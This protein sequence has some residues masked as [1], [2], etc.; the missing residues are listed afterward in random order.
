MLIILVLAEPESKR[1]VLAEVVDALLAVICVPENELC[2]IAD[3]LSVALVFGRPP[4]AVEKV[5]LLGKTEP[6]T[7]A[8]VL[9]TPLSLG[10]LVCM[11]VDPGNSEPG[12]VDPGYI[13]VSM[14]GVIEAKSDDRRM[15]DAEGGLIIGVLIL[16]R[17]DSSELLGVGSE[18]LKSLPA[19]VNPLRVLSAEVESLRALLAEVTLKAVAAA[20]LVEDE[21]SSREP[22]W[23]VESEVME[24][25]AGLEASRVIVEVVVPVKIV[26][27]TI[28]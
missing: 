19:D 22:V 7:V 6:L 12:N 15:I 11:T 3:V 25:F 17:E 1:L 28:L 13:D 21:T 4:V 20:L 24:V 16:E 14:I 8:G 26:D 27:G 5:E 23:T 10:H 2:E 9:N 18:P